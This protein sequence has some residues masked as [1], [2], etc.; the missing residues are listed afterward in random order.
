MATNTVT[1]PITGGTIR[2]TAAAEIFT[3]EAWDGSATIRN[4]DLGT[5]RIVATT[6]YGYQ[7]WVHEATRGGVAGTEFIYGWNDDVVFLPG[8]TG[9]TVEQIAGTGGAGVADAYRFDAWD[10]AATIAGFEVGLDS[11]TATTAYGYQ[12]W[13]REETRD[14][15]A[16]TEFIYGWN[17]DVVF[18]PGVT[19]VT[20]EQILGAG[21]GTGSAGGGAG[22]GAAED[23]YTVVLADDFSQGYLTSNWGNPFDGGVYWNGAW[24]WSA[25]DV[26]VV[27]GE[28]QVSMTRGEDGWWTGGGFNSFKA[29]KDI[30]YGTVEFDA[31]V[32]E[33]QGTMTAILMWPTSDIWPQDGEIDILE[34]PAQ[35]VMHTLHWGGGASGTEDWYDSVRNQSF[36]ETQWNRYKMTWLPGD[37]TIEVNGNVVARWTGD[38]VPDGPMGFGAMGMVA[39]ANDA[40]IGG[41]PDAT[42]PD[43]VTV[44]LDNVVMSQWDGFGG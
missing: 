12:P 34:T 16:G 22:G 40:W 27:N 6:A 26:N 18:L 13:V 42:T 29:G 17:D 14:G 9:V 35:D 3:V 10:G 43:K 2:A 19:G 32:E 5:D 38:A 20:V 15:V 4:F 8:V 31:R 28:M 24:S 44:Y 7:P 30:T 36:D 25:D 33:A 23:G 11:I 37:L 21:G 41:P 1:T 39:S